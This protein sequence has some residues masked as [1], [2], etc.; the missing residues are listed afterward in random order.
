MP[1]R[2]QPLERT[3]DGVDAVGIRTANTEG[4]RLQT[5]GWVQGCRGGP[6]PESRSAV[7]CCCLQLPGHCMCHWCSDTHRSRSLW[8]DC[9]PPVSYTSLI[10]EWKTV[11]NKNML[12]SLLIVENVNINNIC[13]SC[14]AIMDLVFKKISLQ[15]GCSRVYFNGNLTCLT[16]ECVS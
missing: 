4:R 14:I 6:R 8:T 11:P 12:Q 9:P 5:V 3:W 1:E 16:P 15:S 2:K 13:I 10:C 7:V